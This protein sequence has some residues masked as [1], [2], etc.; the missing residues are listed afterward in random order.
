MELEFLRCSRFYGSAGALGPDL[1][2]ALLGKTPR[3]SP[4]RSFDT[5][6]IKLEL[7]FDFK[8]RSLLGACTTVIKSYEEKLGRISLD[9]VDM[10][11]QDVSLEGRPCR[12]SYDGSKLEASL[13]RPLKLNEQ[14]SLRV[15]YKVVHPR[16]GLHFVLPRKSQ[17]VTQVWSQGQPEDSR[18]WFPCHD[19]P[20]EKA[21]S[22]ILATVPEGFVAVSNGVLVQAIKNS[23]NRTLTYH[24]RM[25]HP[26]SVYLIS[27]AAGRFSEI[28][29]KWN[30]VDVLYF[31]EKGREKEA[32][33]GFGKTI[34]MLDFF[35]KKIGVKYPYE[36]YAQVAVADYPGGMENTTSTTQTDAALFDERA[37]LDTD[38]DGLVA[39]ELAHQWFGDLLTCKDWSHAW[40]N[41]G[42]ATYFESLFTEF[43]KGR[44]EFLYEMHR[45]AQTY[46]QEDEKRYRRPIVCPNYKYPWV[47]F[48]RHLYEK[49]AAVLRMLH[50]ELGDSLWWRAV[51]HYVL[52]FK[53]QSVETADLLEAIRESTGKNLKPFF[54][55]WVFKSGYPQYKAQY[56]WDPKKKKAS[57]WILQT[58]R[59]SEESPLFDVPVEILLKGKGYQKSFTERIHKKEHRLEFGLPSEPEIVELDPERTLLKKI[60]FHKPLK[61]W[62]A[63][64]LNGP[65]AMSRIDAV[66]AVAGHG[67]PRAAGL[68]AEAFDREKFWGAQA[69]TA[70]ALGSLKT[71]EAFQALRRRLKTPSH[72][73]RRAVVEAMGNFSHKE[74]ARS[75]EPLLKKDPSYHVEAEA[76]RSL[77][78]IGEPSYFSKVRE[79]LKKKSWWDLVRGA[80]IQGLASFRSEKAAAIFKKHCGPENHFYS[81][82]AAA[83]A[84][85][86]LHG[87]SEEIIPF[88]TGLLKD[89]D[90]R[91]RLAVIST[92]GQ[93]EDE[94]ALEALEEVK[95][96]DPNLRVRLHA[97]EAILR[98]RAGIPKSKDEE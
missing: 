40:L 13:P 44:D 9:A 93:T 46:F 60:K 18:Y 2:S 15:R 85:G 45:Y 17:P 96:K 36:K 90:S 6:H 23:K 73:A 86:S 27:L 87:R 70:L 57:L 16:A 89:P 33:R 72:K 78:K 32:Q 65:N 34:K 37:A 24:W 31:C 20:Q 67:G 43:D 8:K 7:F 63:Q 26:H 74:A 92:L 28:R 59:V 98:I 58:Q 68:L 97:E 41:E 14:A 39:H 91:L 35:S 79:N 22:E 29:Q 42:F 19:D 4:D 80:A 49:G 11:I 62:I 55:Q 1:K 12:W 51:R 61:N 10:K 77:G 38:L 54:D 3:Y 25:D 30:G 71:E 95:E 88:L 53:N 66:W 56:R 21:T 50:A 94:G 76:A 83:R 81:R 82:A 69:E 5:L 84:L 75:L 64:L 52:K 47:L 48:D